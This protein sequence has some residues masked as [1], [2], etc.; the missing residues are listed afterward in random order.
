MV[1]HS[2]IRPLKRYRLEGKFWEVM[3]NITFNLHRKLFIKNIISIELLIKGKGVASYFKTNWNTSDCN[4]YLHYFQKH[5]WLIM[6]NWCDTAFV[7]IRFF[8]SWKAIYV[9]IHINYHWIKYFLDQFVIKSTIMTGRIYQTI[10]ILKLNFTVLR[11]RII[12]N[13]KL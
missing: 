1:C 4:L 12:M 13:L 11:K 10:T 6:I 2:S 8:L 3:Q 5:S 7:Q 9:H